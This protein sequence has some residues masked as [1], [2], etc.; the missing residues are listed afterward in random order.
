M[1]WPAQ[2]LCITETSHISVLSQ[3]VM[4]YRSCA[5][6]SWI[7]IANSL[8]YYTRPKNNLLQ[9]VEKSL[10]YAVLQFQLGFSFL[11]QVFH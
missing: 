10:V 1:G 9:K 11:L 7:S 3:I 4:V 6:V 8:P 5:S 2:V